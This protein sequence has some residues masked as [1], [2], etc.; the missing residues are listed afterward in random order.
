MKESLKAKLP[1]LGVKDF[2]FVK[3]R[4]KATSVLQVGPGTEYNYTV[5]KKMAGQGFCQCI[6]EDKSVCCSCR[7]LKSGILQTSA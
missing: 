4:Q 1:L 3:V 7:G 2:D 5:V 6:C